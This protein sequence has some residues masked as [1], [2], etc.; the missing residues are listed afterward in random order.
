MSIEENLLD[1][2]LK[3]IRGIVAL[4]WI[5]N[6][7]RQAAGFWEDGQNS[8]IPT[9]LCLIH[10]EI[11]EA[12]EGY[13][14]NLRDDKLTNRPAMEVELADAVIRIA[15]LAQHMGYDLAG[16]IIAK[17]HYNNNRADHKPEARAATNGKKF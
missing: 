6:E 9:K 12:M 3:I 10:S 7:V 16:A 8:N 15:D 14:K 2:E 17:M 13:R 5:A 4:S 11:S 1:Q